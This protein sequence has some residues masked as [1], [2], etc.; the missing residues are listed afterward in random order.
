MSN[1]AWAYS[2]TTVKDVFATMRNRE[3]SELF[4]SKKIPIDDVT[5]HKGIN[6]VFVSPFS[7]FAVKTDPARLATQLLAVRLSF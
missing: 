4:S 1:T 5:V 6:V 7:A 3:H 2:E